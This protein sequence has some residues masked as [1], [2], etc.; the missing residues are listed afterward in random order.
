M[1]HECQLASGSPDNFTAGDITW[2]CQI[3]PHGTLYFSSELVS[4]SPTYL[5][6]YSLPQL[7]WKDADMETTEV[8]ITVYT[9]ADVREQSNSDAVASCM[10]TLLEQAQLAGHLE[11]ILME[12]TVDLYTNDSG[13][14][15]CKYYFVAPD[16][17]ILFWEDHF[18]A[19]HLFGGVKGITSGHI[20]AF[21]PFVLVTLHNRCI[22]YA[23]EAEFW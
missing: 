15:E 6:T 12:L 20:S 5:F 14:L 2:N 9:D 21:F 16:R 18:E 1:R 19:K 11:G 7:M 13:E 10:R 17:R 8:E 22:E 23:M 4:L 3:H